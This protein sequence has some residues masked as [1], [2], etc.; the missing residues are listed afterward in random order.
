MDVEHNAQRSQKS[1]SSSIQLS[2]NFIVCC[3][4]LVYFQTPYRAFFAQHQLRLELSEAKLAPLLAPLRGWGGQGSCA[5]TTP[6]AVTTVS[7]A[8]RLLA[9]QAIPCRKPRLLPGGSTGG[10]PR[11]SA[12]P[13]PQAESR[14]H[15]LSA[16]TLA[17][18]APRAS[19][20]RPL[21]LGPPS[22]DRE[23]ASG[24]SAVRGG[25]PSP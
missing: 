3:R 12:T 20:G 6:S 7:A 22:L 13:T 10:L 18:P 11:P 21:P 4:F 9:P 2:R 15:S 25:P 5:H 1:S 14:G 23:S 8:R 17:S 24:I 19:F 16:P